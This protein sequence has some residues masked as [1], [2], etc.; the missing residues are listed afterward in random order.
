MCAHINK[1][2]RKFDGGGEAIK[3]LRVAAAAA[4]AAAVVLVVVVVM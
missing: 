3:T 2:F 4:T 1:T